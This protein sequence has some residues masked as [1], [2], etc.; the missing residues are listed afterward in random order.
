MP[1]RG[2][3]GRGLDA[4]IPSRK[5]SNAAKEESAAGG[6][7]TSS[8]PEKEVKRK[9]NQTA[10]PAKRTGS[11]TVVK[12][13]KQRRLAVTEE[14]KKALSKQND[15]SEEAR[16]MA[17]AILSGGLKAG[18]SVSEEEEVK[19]PAETKKKVNEDLPKTEK[20]A[21]QETGTAK[22]T[23]QSKKS[24]KN[25]VN[26][27][28]T[29]R[30]HSASDKEEATAALADSDVQSASALPD[31]SFVKEETQPVHEP[32]SGKTG[33]KEKNDNS[34]GE[35]I[36]MR[37][38]LVE[39]N[40]EQPRKYF[41]EDAI[42]ELADSIRQFG[43]I[44]PLLVQKKDG[45][46]EIIAGERRWRA[47]KKAG[48]K[49]VPVIVREFSSQEAVEISLIENI[50]REDLNPI[51]EA[52][53]YDRLVTEYGLAQE[54]VAGRVSKSRSAVANSMRL[55]RLVPEVQKM[56]ETGELSEGHARA[57]IPIIAEDVQIKT[58]EKI[59]KE[60]LT[61]RQT[62]KIVRELL[63]PSKTKI[64]MRD[65]Q[66][67][68]LLQSLSENLKA[69]LGTKVSIHQSG[70]NKGRIEIEYYS[71]DELDRLYELL[72]AIR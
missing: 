27:A 67:E 11:E 17:D 4:L 71:D 22:K 72:R 10:E 49:E 26:T 44:S 12:K 13:S 62:E 42:D 38:S 33:T 47:A 64:R 68:A 69:A 65:E 29:G 54:E 24:T 2:G 9:S 70:R 46:Y 60:R 21:E 16:R 58:A 15:I 39:P 61:V 56:V 36:N 53:A 5:P 63:H 57:I 7:K 19:K 28:K 32:E 50:Q 14:V 31:S 66:R 37:L 20:A 6:E 52:K 48:L 45:Y 34:G 1:K 25:S 8:A 3:L 51:E 35:I 18:V 43:I 59:I 55:L 40:R 30:T 41:D 23:E